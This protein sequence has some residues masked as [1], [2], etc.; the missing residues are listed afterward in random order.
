VLGIED[1]TWGESVAAAVVPVAGRGIA[2]NELRAWCKERMSPYKVPRVFK[3]PA[4]LPRNAMGKV[5]K[6]DVKKLFA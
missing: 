5:T 4:L 3:F 6:P 2:E 1:A